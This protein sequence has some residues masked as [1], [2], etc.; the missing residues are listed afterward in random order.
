MDHVGLHR[1][2]EACGRGTWR[3][4]V[5]SSHESFV[6]P[7]LDAMGCCDQVDGCEHGSCTVDVSG[8]VRQSSK[9]GHVTGINRPVVAVDGRFAVDDPTRLVGANRRRSSESHTVRL[10]RRRIRAATGH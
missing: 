4:R 9:K 6:E 2:L 10:S 1:P 7:R 8:R 3:K 5:T